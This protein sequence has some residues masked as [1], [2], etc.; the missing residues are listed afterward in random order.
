MRIE[1]NLSDDLLFPIF[2]LLR[3]Q[4]LLI[5]ERVSSSWQRVVHYFLVRLS[6][7]EKSQIFRKAAKKGQLS[8]VQL[9]LT[10]AKAAL[11][12]YD[13]EGALVEASGKGHLSVVRFI[14][15][16][17]SKNIGFCAKG[18]A[19]WIA[20]NWELLPMVQLIL[21]MEHQAISSFAKGQALIL[22]ARNGRFAIVQEILHQVSPAITVKDKDKAYKFSCQRLHF[23]VGALLLTY[24]YAEQLETFKN[25]LQQVANCCLHPLTYLYKIRS[26]QQGSGIPLTQ[27]QE[28]TRP[29]SFVGGKLISN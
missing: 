29:L 12:V 6:K 23:A 4:E 9:L 3:W 24:K 16:Q 13:I 5:V 7:V 1:W 20:V 8:V 27:G 21:K 15:S 18:T 25:S 28:N 2:S 19:L 26:S 11:S 17:E 14:L 22:A 10:H